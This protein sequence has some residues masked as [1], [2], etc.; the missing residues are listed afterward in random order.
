MS[1]KLHV[2][3]KMVTSF[4]D[5]NLNKKGSVMSLHFFYS[6]VECFLIYFLIEYSSK[7][8]L[9]PF[10]INEKFQYSKFLQNDSDFNDSL[11]VIYY[12]TA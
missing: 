4:F 1:I 12:F 9:R 2:H 11:T 3:V 8:C 6:S 7:C 10:I 5:V